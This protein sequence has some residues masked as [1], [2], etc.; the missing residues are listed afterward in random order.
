[1]S[2]RLNNLTFSK[3]DV[4]K[5]IAYLK[6][7][8]V[9]AGSYGVQQRFKK[10]CE[11]FKVINDNLFYV[12]P[13]KIL[14][15]IPKEDVEDKVKEILDEPA[16]LGKGINQLNA[17]VKDTKGY[18]GISRQNLIDALKRSSYYQLSF[19]RR[20]MA[21]KA[22]LLNSCHEIWVYD[23]ID[24]NYISNHNNG[25]RYIFSCMDLFSKFCWLEP[26]KNKTSDEVLKAFKNII[27]SNA[28]PKSGKRF[29]TYTLSDRGGELK[30]VLSTYLK[31][32]G[33]IQ[34]NPPS[35]S[36]QKNIENL[37]NQVRHKLRVYFVKNNTLK[38]TNALQQVAESINTNK[39]KVLKATPEQIMDEFYRNNDMSAYAKKAQERLKRRFT[40]NWGQNHL[41]VRDRVRVK[42]TS[43]FSSLRQREKQNEGKKNIVTYS[44]ELF[45]INKIIKPKEGAQIG[46]PSYFLVN[47]RTR[48]IVR[49]ESG[50]PRF[51]S[52]TELLRVDPNQQT[53][54]ITM[55]RAA[56]LNQVDHKELDEEVPPVQALVD[57]PIPPPKIPTPPVGWKTK[58]WAFFLV[59]KKFDVE[60]SKGPIRCEV[61]AVKY[62]RKF[63]SYIVDYKMANGKKEF[64]SLSDALSDMKSEPFFTP[65]LQAVIDKN[66]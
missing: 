46:Y 24:L 13:D 8:E 22:Y 31:Q 52:A 56:V 3:D 14:T 25:Y 20:K 15:V 54:N 5:M 16:A 2:K 23:L 38:W 50:K 60:T 19:G 64:Q 41:V 4:K 63:K 6:T 48:K 36:P 62:D 53:P 42:M 55:K 45:I 26:L 12:L 29:P 58:E 39:S 32:N 57:K 10:K 59:G 47:D 37:N 43:L 9:P 18:L 66:K 1:M 65:E 61:T 27:E 28:V 44:P 7:G 40:Q 17:Y 51:F 30:G 11:G 35:Y 21:S 33:V 34:L 49:G